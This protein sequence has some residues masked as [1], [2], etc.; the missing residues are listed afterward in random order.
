M[1]LTFKVDLGSYTSMPLPNLVT[2]SPT[3]SEINFQ[4]FFS[5]T[6]RQTDRKRCIRA[7]RALAQVGSKKLKKIIFNK[8]IFVQILSHLIFVTSSSSRTSTLLLVMF[9]GCCGYYA[10]A[11]ITFIYIYL[12]AY[13][14]RTRLNACDASN[15]Y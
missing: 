12:W 11:D 7:H 14:V 10:V 2:Q 6:D 4:A 9:H 1:T 13:A 3:I 5:Q 15:R 8:R